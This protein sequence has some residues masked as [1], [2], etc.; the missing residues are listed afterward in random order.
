MAVVEESDLHVVKV[1]AVCGE[2]T[3]RVRWI[4]G[5]RLIETCC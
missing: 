2:K 4:S 1:F 3:Q 5:E